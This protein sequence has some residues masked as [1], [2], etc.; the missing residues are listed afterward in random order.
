VYSAFSATAS[1][2]RPSFHACSAVPSSRNTAARPSSCTGLRT[3]SRAKAD[4]SFR[5]AK[6]SP[7]PRKRRSTRTSPKNHVRPW[8]ELV[9]VAATS[10]NRSSATAGCREEMR[11]KHSI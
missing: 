2:R 5:A 10:S 7:I 4:A 3:S 8:F 11:W 1:A 6:L 9:S